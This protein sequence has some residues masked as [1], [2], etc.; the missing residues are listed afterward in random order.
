MVGERESFVFEA[1][2]G[3]QGMRINDR[4]EEENT[5]KNPYPGRGSQTFR[6]NHWI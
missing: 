5:T 1:I 2:L 3:F 4:D 6:V